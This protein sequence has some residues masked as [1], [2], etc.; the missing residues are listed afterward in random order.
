M[1]KGVR[2]MSP[3]STTQSAGTSSKNHTCQ[4]FSPLRLYAMAISVLLP[5]MPPGAQVTPCIATS[6]EQD[7]LAFG[8]SAASWVRVE[9]TAHGNLLLPSLICNQAKGLASVQDSLQAPSW[10]LQAAVLLCGLAGLVCLVYFGTSR[11]R[12]GRGSFH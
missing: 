5:E 3:I 8:N 1:R 7:K 12:L 6:Q 9:W 10:I 2:E 11:S 4:V